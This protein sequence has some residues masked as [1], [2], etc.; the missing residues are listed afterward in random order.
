[1][2]YTRCAICRRL[3][4]DP[5]SVAYGIGPECRGG[6]VR[7]GW[8]FPKPHWKMQKGKAVLSGFAGGNPRPVPGAGDRLPDELLNNQEDTQDEQASDCFE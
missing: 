3:L 7:R 1:M 5:V 8:K 6:L 2:P 4:K